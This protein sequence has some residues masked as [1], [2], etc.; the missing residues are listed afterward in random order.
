M[1]VIGENPESDSSSRGRNRS[2]NRNA[3]DMKKMKGIEFAKKA[4]VEEAQLFHTPKQTHY[5]D[6]NPYL[7][8]I[9]R[10][11]GRKNVTSPITKPK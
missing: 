7:G 1:C 3:G 11:K 6:Y 10:P 8:P 9:K 4:P 2:S 5:F